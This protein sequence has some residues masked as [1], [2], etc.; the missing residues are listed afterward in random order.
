[1]AENFQPQPFTEINSGMPPNEDTKAKQTQKQWRPHDE[2]LIVY[3]QT[4]KPD[5]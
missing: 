4:N 1:M 2:T 5:Q 3:K